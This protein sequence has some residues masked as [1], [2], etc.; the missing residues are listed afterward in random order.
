MWNTKKSWGEN[1]DKQEGILV[2]AKMM[3]N[4]DELLQFSQLQNDAN[5][6]SI[7]SFSCKRRGKSAFKFFFSKSI[8][9]R[10]EE[11]SQ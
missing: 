1:E 7:Y 6:A 10:Q 11:Y 2:I 5:A 3:N 4:T 9:K 8:K